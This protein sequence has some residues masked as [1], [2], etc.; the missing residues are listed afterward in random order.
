MTKAQK[1]RQQYMYWLIKDRLN[2]LVFYT[3]LVYIDQE[4]QS[5]G[6]YFGKWYKS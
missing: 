6:S 1:E 3:R 5:K 4:A 2:C